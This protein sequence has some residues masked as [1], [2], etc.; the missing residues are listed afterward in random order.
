[1]SE[2]VRVLSRSP[3]SLGRERP[4]SSEPFGP[5]SGVSGLLW[6]RSDSHSS[7]GAA[8]L[9]A[10]GRSWGLS[11]G[12][13]DGSKA[14]LP[15]LSFLDI[16]SLHPGHQGLLPPTRTTAAAPVLPLS[17]SLGRVSSNGNLAM[18]FPCSSSLGALQISRAHICCE[19]SPPGLHTHSRWAHCHTLGPPCPYFSTW[20]LRPSKPYCAVTSPRVLSH[21]HPYLNRIDGSLPGIPCSTLYTC[22]AEL[23]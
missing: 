11:C 18:F 6:L 16:T 21:L 3:E 9:G 19:P 20:H 12:G 17:R 10:L 5:Q 22:L 14:S 2:E 7:G 13:Q 23:G 15:A 8:V 4:L 1:M